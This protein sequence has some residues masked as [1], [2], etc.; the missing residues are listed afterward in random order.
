M[1]E[2][3]ELENGVSF[4]EQINPHEAA[5][6]YVSSRMRTLSTPEQLEFVSPSRTISNFELCSPLSKSEK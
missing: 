2:K 6:G 3:E 5:S 4:S 1:T